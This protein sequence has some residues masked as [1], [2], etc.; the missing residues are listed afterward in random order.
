MPYQPRSAEDVSK[1]RYPVLQVGRASYDVMLE[2][3]GR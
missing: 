2:T 3:R 1:Y